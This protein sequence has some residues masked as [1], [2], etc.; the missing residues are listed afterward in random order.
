MVQYG[1]QRSFKRSA[2]AV[3]NSRLQITASAV[4]PLLPVSAGLR[5]VFAS[6]STHGFAVVSRHCRSTVRRTPFRAIRCRDDAVA[7]LPLTLIAP[8]QPFGWVVKRGGARWRGF[9]DCAV[10][11]Q[12]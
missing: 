10:S 2:S 8:P 4:S 5:S 11:L 12:S 9:E 1:Q 7:S 6:L 3:S